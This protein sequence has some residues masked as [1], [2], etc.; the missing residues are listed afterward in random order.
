M[1]NDVYKIDIP[2]GY[3]NVSASLNVTNLSPF[4]TCNEDL[5]SKSNSV[6]EGEDDS[7]PPR[8]INLDDLKGLGGPI[9][10]VRTKKA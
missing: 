7:N 8:V 1:N 2:N 10:R 3:G 4:E 5:D 9:T 6:Q